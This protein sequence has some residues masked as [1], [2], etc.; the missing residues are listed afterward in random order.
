MFPLFKTLF[1]KRFKN[2]TVVL[3]VNTDPDKT[4]SYGFKPMAIFR[5]YILSLLIAVIFFGTILYLTPLGS[6]IFSKQDR[7]LRSAVTDVRERITALQD[8]LAVRDLQLTSIRNVLMNSVDTTYVLND[9]L[10]YDAINQ[11]GGYT[12]AADIPEFESLSSI[13]VI[14]SSSFS[15][16]L[17]FPVSFPLNGTLTRNFD[18]ETGH[19]GID[20]AAPFDSYI[21]SVSD[22]SV[23]QAGWAVDYGY[24]ISIQ[25][26]DGYLSIYKH[27]SSIYKVKGDMVL[28][29]DIVGKV[30][31]TGMMSSGPHLH[32]ELWRDGVPQ[33][34]SRFFN[35]L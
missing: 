14:Y 28:Q 9:G 26:S 34:P 10:N 8:S 24:V 3:W 32:F 2:L 18:A 19:Y 1:N 31:N 29:G 16:S 23:V 27:G 12:V 35:N 11:T 21:R 7:L 33:N 6:M 20:I 17:Q 30:G 5:F 15:G 22:G 4:E 13:D 25:H